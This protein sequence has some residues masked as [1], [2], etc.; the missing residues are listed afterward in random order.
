MNLLKGQ[1]VVL[2]EKIAQTGTD[3][4]NRPTFTTQK[5]EVENVLITPTSD[6][7]IVNE[8]QMYGKASVY[9]LSIPKGDTHNWEDSTI[10]IWD[11]DLEKWKKF[12]SFGTVIKY[13]EE[14][15]PLD[16]NGKVKVDL[17]E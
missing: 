4:F 8:I 3:P 14:L 10:E 1:T 16:W 17:D 15:V 11:K 12:K 9:T 13:Q 7:D 2:H 5:V 6:T